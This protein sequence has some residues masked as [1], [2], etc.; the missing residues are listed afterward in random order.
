MEV[1]SNEAPN[2]IENPPIPLDISIQQELDGLSPLTPLCCIYRVPERLRCAIPIAYTPQVVSIGPLHHGSK[3]LIG[4]EEHKMRY[5]QDFIS[6][7]KISLKDYLQM[8]R[9]Q[10]EK[11][12]NCYAETIGLESDAFVK[13]ILVDAAFIIEML[14][15][16]HY[17][18]LRDVNDRIFNKPWMR[19]D[20]WYDMLLLENQL[21]FF[22][23]DELYDK[24]DSH[25]NNENE[26]L[27]LVHLSHY[28]FQSQMDLM[29]MEGTTEKL[30][31]IRSSS[32]EVKHFVDFIKKLYLTLD[33]PPPT[34]TTTT[35]TSARTR[36]ANKPTTQA[37]RELETLTAPSMTELHLAGVKFKVR[38]SENLFDIQFRDG[39]LEIPKLNI[40]PETERTITN[41]MALNN[42]IAKRIT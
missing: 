20:V 25:I 38:S 3:G 31:K 14:L 9:G 21:P 11:L 2:D 19:Q 26:K 42:A 32:S 18:F 1:S 41:L 13:I 28:F 29:H 35:K 33:Q 17:N 36:A 16:N 39:I 7:T 10:E 30:E 34:G 22:I 12:R 27:S 23:L 40:S 4:M 24:V 8:I 37:E 6:R 15:K 5:L